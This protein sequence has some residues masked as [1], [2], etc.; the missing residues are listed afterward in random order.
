MRLFVSIANGVTLDAD[1]I[2]II[3]HHLITATTRGF[4]S[5]GYKQGKQG[6]IACY[7]VSMWKEGKM[8]RKKWGRRYIKGDMRECGFNGEMVRDRWRAKIR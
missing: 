5:W 7:G 8:S 4:R 3:G 1:S 2:R 6:R